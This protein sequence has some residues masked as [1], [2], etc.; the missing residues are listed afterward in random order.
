MRNGNCLVLLE[1]DMN[2]RFEEK[3]NLNR[4]HMSYPVRTG[5]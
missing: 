1:Q 2:E 3:M 4:K 5:N